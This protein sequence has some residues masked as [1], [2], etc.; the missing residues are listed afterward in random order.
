MSAFLMVV[1]APVTAAW[2]EDGGEEYAPA[3]EQQAAYVFGWHDHQ[4]PLE[5]RGG[6]T[7][8]PPITLQTTPSDEWNALQ[9][10]DGS[11]QERD[12]A[13]ILALAGDYKASFDF[14]ETEVYTPGEK[15][16]TPY[17]SWGTERVH[18]LIDEPDHIVLQHIMTMFIA[19]EDG[20]LSDP[21]VVKHWRQDWHWEPSTLLEYQGMGHFRV[22]SVSDDEARG[23]WSQT[24][25]QVDDTPRYAMIGRW[26]HSPAYSEWV[27]GNAWRPLPRRERTA[28]SD[29]QVL[30]GWN[31][32]TVNPTG[33]VHFQDNLK[34]VLSEPGT[35]SAE[36]PAV[37]RELGVNRY[38][39]IVG[40]DF[41]AGD[42]YWAATEPYWALVRDTWNPK[43]STVGEFVA[44]R[45]CGEQAV[46]ERFFALAQ[47]L[48]EGKRFREKRLQ[49]QVDEVVACMAE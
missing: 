2:A 17:R 16:A 34:T 31:R 30:G 35:V 28:R 24:V 7:K 23:Q 3:E 27:S 12:R 36:M 43:V 40:H 20:T 33:W 19:G 45:T 44:K 29:Y 6:T 4:G 5:L 13:A 10:V 39:R 48:T 46:F 26:N 21:I 41:S 38:E 9:S 22:R 42:T 18:V 32:L 8:G 14:L 11:A 47:P 1:V 15:P 25:Y 37:A 49:R